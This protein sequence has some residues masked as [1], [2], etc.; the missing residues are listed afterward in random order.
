MVVLVHCF[1]VGLLVL[2]LSTRVFS[3]ISLGDMHYWKPSYVGV[4]LL[5]MY[6]CN[7]TVDQA[8]EYRLSINFEMFTFHR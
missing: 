8:I 7:N 6:T 5:R 2:N 1:E 4:L 3:R